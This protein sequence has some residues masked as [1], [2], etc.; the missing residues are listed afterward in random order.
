MRVLIILILTLSIPGFAATAAQSRD[1]HLALERAIAEALSNN[2]SYKIAELDPQIATE[3]VTAQEAA[4]DTEIFA[5]GN[6]TQFEQ[7]TT[8]TQVTGTSS[9]NRNW[10]AGARKRLV[11]GTTVT[12]Q[13][14]LDRRDSD[15]G[16]NNF[17]LSQSA[18]I[19]L[20]VRQP[21]M[22]GFGK[23]INLAQI[24]RAKAGYDASS[25]EFKR[26]VQS[27]LAQV[28]EAY[29]RVAR[30][31]EQLELNKSNLTVSE[32]LLEEAIERERIG[33]ATQI[34]VLQARAFNAESKEDIIETT[35]S[36][37]DAYDRLLALMGALPST[38]FAIGSGE[39]VAALPD[40][41]IAFPEFSET[42]TLALESAPALSAQAAVIEQR[43]LERFSAQGASKPNLDLVVS[44]AYSGIDDQ[45][46]TEAY[47]N[48]FD[49]DGKAWSI[50]L[51]F[52]MPWN[53]RAEK[54]E[55]SIADKRL[56]KEEIR[57]EEIKQ[58]LYQEV[59]S[60]WRALE[61]VQQSVEAAKL[62]VS[63]QEASFER[64]TGKFEEG[65][66]AFRDVLEAQRDLDQARVRL[67]TSKFNQLT[68]EI[69]LANLTGTI[70]ERHGIEPRLPGEG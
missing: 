50:G 11:Y 70:F 19:S 9:D 59:R 8:F 41:R 22:N 16:V 21:L 28:E 66:S 29:W 10:R 36:L 15:A 1:G 52:S 26:V 14:T 27:L 34:E 43:R 4:F 17:P 3:S 6:V 56:Q 69:E 2:F 39:S 24:E 55:F 38:G 42:W 61:A 47:Q 48:T 13:T 54:A 53:R 35:R 65:L 57:Y 63:L 64:E 12:A 58:S 25:A 5:S 60:A 31:Q 33:L 40:K 46:A 23:E 30:W 67:L 62:T 37:G 51:E 32:T 44:G 45:T 18:D 20:T 7:A 68:A 49:R